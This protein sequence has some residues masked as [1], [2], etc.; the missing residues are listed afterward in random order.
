MIGKD[1]SFWCK[2]NSDPFCERKRGK[3]CIGNDCP[4]KTI[5]RDSK[6][7]LRPKDYGKEAEGQ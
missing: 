4:D 5:E 7:R 3:D 6:L 1:D 2:W